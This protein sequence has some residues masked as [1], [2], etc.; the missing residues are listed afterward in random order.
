MMAVVSFA[1]FAGAF[2]ISVYTLSITITPRLDRILGALRKQ[3]PEERQPLAA[4][5]RAEQRI[6]V[7]RWAAQ[8][9]PA[10]GYRTRVAA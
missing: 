6:A 8:A 5:V 4:L 1:V 10:P 2:A 7:R 3:T 9:R